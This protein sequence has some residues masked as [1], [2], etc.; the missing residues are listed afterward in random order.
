MMKSLANFE[1]AASSPDEHMPYVVRS[2]YSAPQ[3]LP[4]QFA[5]MFNALAV[6]LETC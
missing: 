4:V 1:A 5:V 6:V 3:C 2:E